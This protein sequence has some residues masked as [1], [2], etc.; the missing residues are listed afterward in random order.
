MGRKHWIDQKSM[1]TERTEKRGVPEPGDPGCIGAAVNEVEVGI[2]D[3]RWLTGRLF[4]TA[5]EEA[6][7]DSPT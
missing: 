5:A 3:R 1:A 2:D 6:I 7:G 4:S